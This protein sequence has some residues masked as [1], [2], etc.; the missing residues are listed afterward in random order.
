MNLGSIWLKTKISNDIFGINPVHHRNK[1]RNFQSF[2]DRY[3]LGRTTIDSCQK[4][5]PLRHTI[6]H[7]V[8]YEFLWFRKL[9]LLL[10]WKVL[11]SVGIPSCYLLQ[12]WGIVFMNFRSFIYN[13]CSDLHFLISSFYWRKICLN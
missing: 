5:A 10:L 6:Q 4:R 1:S 13:E 3:R 8:F 2:K 7:D 9:R 11:I 12:I